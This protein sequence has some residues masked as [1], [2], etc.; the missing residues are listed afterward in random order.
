VKSCGAERLKQ[1][2]AGEDVQLVLEN[3]E[4]V[5]VLCAQARA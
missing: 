3:T 1:G 5:Q 4:D 2:G